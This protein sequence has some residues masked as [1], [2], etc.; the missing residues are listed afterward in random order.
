MSESRGVWRTLIL[1]SSANVW[2]ILAC[3]AE[4]DA[5]PLLWA[6]C[7]QTVVRRVT[8]M[9]SSSAMEETSES[10]LRTVS[11]NIPESMPGCY[12]ICRKHGDAS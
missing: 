6:H 4:V 10:G 3:L 11:P 1:P 5:S 9:N 2:H 12:A 7:I 8:P